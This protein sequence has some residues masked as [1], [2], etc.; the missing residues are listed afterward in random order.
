MMPPG[1]GLVGRCTGGQT[2][3]D[4]PIAPLTPSLFAC[5]G[6]RV[7]CRCAVARARVCPEPALFQ[8]RDGIDLFPDEPA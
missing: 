6:G 2:I 8:D 4:V 3:L 1:N 5:P 7:G